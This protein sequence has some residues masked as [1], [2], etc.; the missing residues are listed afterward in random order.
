MVVYLVPVESS[1]LFWQRSGLGL[2][3][4]T[5]LCI[6]CSR[7]S[8]HGQAQTHIWWSEFIFSSVSNT[9][10]QGVEINS[11][12]HKVHPLLIFTQYD[13]DLSCHGAT[14][15]IEQRRISNL[16]DQHVDWPCQARKSAAKRPEALQKKKEQRGEIYDAAAAGAFGQSWVPFQ[17]QIPKRPWAMSADGIVIKRDLFLAGGEPQPMFLFGKWPCVRHGQAWYSGNTHGTAAVAH[18]PHSFW[19]TKNIWL[20]EGKVQVHKG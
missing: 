6:V 15:R 10:V 16:A 4:Y 8:H 14:V 3:W 7:S 12:T 11:G 17:N 5:L 18:V 2:I 19:R 13:G 9:P 1:T 20:S